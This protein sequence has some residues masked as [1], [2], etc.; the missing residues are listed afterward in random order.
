MR[1]TAFLSSSICDIMPTKGN[2]SKLDDLQAALS[3]MLELKKAVDRIQGG[4]TLLACPFESSSSSPLMTGSSS[5]SSCDRFFL[6]TG[7]H[8]EARRLAGCVV[9]DA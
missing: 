9:A 3:Q 6:C 2:I 7:Q 5:P 4:L 1:S 8:L